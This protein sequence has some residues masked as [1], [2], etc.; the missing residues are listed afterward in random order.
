MQAGRGETG[1]T[2]TAPASVLRSE[3]ETG[4]K[5]QF[6]HVVSAALGSV[7]LRG[8]ETCAPAPQPGPP[9]PDLPSLGPEKWEP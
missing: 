2:D 9:I 3:G 4:S 1:R 8:I 6:S 7:G 5:K